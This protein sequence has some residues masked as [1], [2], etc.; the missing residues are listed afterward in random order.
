MHMY[1]IPIYSISLVRDGSIKSAQKQMR[2]SLDAIDLFRSMLVGADRE[3]FLVAMLDQ[4]NKVVGVNVVSVGS[5]T[6]GIVH[7]REVFKPAILSNAAAIICCHNHPS[8]D[9]QPSHEDQ[10]LTTRLHAAGTLLGITVLDHIII[11][12]GT[13]DTFSFADHGLLGNSSTP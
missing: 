10:V 2:S 11:G 4:K 12:D 8:G 5:L 13:N 3:H 6:A 9:P 7:P 1:Q